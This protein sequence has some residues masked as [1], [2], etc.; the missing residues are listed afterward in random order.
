MPLAG[1]RVWFIG[2]SSNEELYGELVVRG[3]RY[4]GM[5][6]GTVVVKGVD[7]KEEAFNGYAVW[8]K[9]LSYREPVLEES[10]LY[11]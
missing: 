6:P 5:V 1:D 4:I 9:D 8:A 7:N 11:D 3:V 10:Y 2:E